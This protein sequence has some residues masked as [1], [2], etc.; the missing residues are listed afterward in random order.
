MRDHM[1]GFPA[2]L[3]ALREPEPEV[4]KVEKSRPA[5]FVDF[6]TGD[7]APKGVIGVDMA[8]PDGGKTV[9]TP[10]FKGAKQAAETKEITLGDLRMAYFR[11]ADKYGLKAAHSLRREFGVNAC[12]QLKPEQW[13]EFIATAERRL[14]GWIKWS[15]GECPVGKNVRVEVR[16]RDNATA[17]A[18]ESDHWVWQHDGS[19]GDIVEYRVVKS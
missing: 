18:T 6:E 12:M 7:W 2:L 9:I 5:A 11:V 16:F 17:G 4:V 10:R 14:D 13:A 1:L 19:S 8:A 3:T 15:G